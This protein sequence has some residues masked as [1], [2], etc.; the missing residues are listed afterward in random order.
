MTG[1]PNRTA[2]EGRI[3]EIIQ[4]ARLK[5]RQVAIYKI[6]IASLHEINEVIGGEGGDE[7]LIEVSRRLTSTIADAYIARLSGTRFAV[8]IEC[9]DKLEA[10]AVSKAFSECLASSLEIKSRSIK[11]RFRIG[12]VLFP[13][14]GNGQGPLMAN[15][16]IALERARQLSGNGV[17]FYDEATDRL[18]HRRRSL[19]QDM[20]TALELDQF[21]LHFQPQCDLASM[22]IVGFEGLLRWRHPAFGL[23]PPSEFIPIAEETGLIVPIGKW[24][25]KEG[26]RIAALWPDKLKV[27]LN[28]SP[29]QLK[30]ADIGAEVIDAIKSSGLPP[31]RL[32]LEITEV[33]ADR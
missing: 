23:V 17:C 16:N 4:T 29:L 33:N 1:L 20:Q 32:E 5:G 11:L 6:N 24:V 25:L 10:Q 12:A 14:D 2:F 3:D 21:E 19:A 7:L 30:S 18:M 28:F 22:T 31:W 13:H 27:A 9:G 26:C 15:A 8:V